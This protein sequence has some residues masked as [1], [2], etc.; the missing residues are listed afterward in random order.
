MNK[1]GRYFF[2]PCLQCVSSATVR[3]TTT[4]LRYPRAPLTPGQVQPGGV[5]GWLAWGDAM[6]HGPLPLAGVGSALPAAES[7]AGAF[8]AAAE[9]GR[10]LL[11]TAGWV[12]RLFPSSAA[13]VD[14]DPCLPASG[15]CLCYLKALDLTSSYPDP[16][17]PLPHIG[18]PDS[19]PK[20]V[21]PSGVFS[22][23]I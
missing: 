17:P 3:R 9:L 15:P 23:S 14:L 10:R 22:C 2:Y 4:S 5:S 12:G 1:V 20:T 18:V 16:G 13:Y 8:Y 7:A 11:A 19:S 21:R 6:A